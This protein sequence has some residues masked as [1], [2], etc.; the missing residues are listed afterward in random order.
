MKQK[1]EPMEE[2][3][4][5]MDQETTITGK[6]FRELVATVLAGVASNPAYAYDPPTETVRRAVRLVDALDVEIADRI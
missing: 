2:L 3:Q 6:T 5:V 1:D 4:E